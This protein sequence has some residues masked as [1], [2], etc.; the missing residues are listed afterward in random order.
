MT[1]P[2]EEEQG[3]FLGGKVQGS[4]FG[5]AGGQSLPADSDL[6]SDSLVGEVVPLGLACLGAPHLPLWPCVSAGTRG[7]HPRA[8][9]SWPR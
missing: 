6:G 4:T 9:G 5:G 1:Q 2:Q 7:S 3:A 8:V